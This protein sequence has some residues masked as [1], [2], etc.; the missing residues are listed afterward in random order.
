[1]ETRASHMVVGLIVVAFTVA[2]LA[3]TIWI[4]KVDLEAEYN[5]YDIYFEESVAGLANRSVV[6]YQGIPVGEVQEIDLLAT[7]TSKVHVWIRVRSEVPVS[8]ATIAAL[9][10]QGLTGVAYIE[11]AGGSPDAPPL[12]AAPSQERAVIPSEASAF[13]EIF[14]NTPELLD[15]A[16]GVMGQ[17]NKLLGDNNL[18]EVAGTLRNVNRLTGNLADGTEDLPVLV[19]EAKDMVAQLVATGSAIEKL[20]LTGNGML[21]GE[22]GALVSDARTTMASANA[23]MQRLDGLVAANEPAV[24]QFVNKSL[25]EITRM[26]A[27]L[28]KTARSLSRLVTRVERN[29][30][31][32][33]FG[34]N[35]EEYDLKTRSKEQKK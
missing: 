27:D 30:G 21:E 26:I 9:Q 35:E 15:Q 20:A 5:D 16:L 12:L 28:R 13:A 31:E 18:E 7:D 2:L 22:V 11:L 24:T 32:V 10:F 1:M 23:L 14:M 33:I 3:F 19:K 8:E 25:P 17:V 29:P 34:G 6:Y 4:A